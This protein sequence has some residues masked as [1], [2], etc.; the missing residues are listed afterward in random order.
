M[1][2]SYITGS[3]GLFFNNMFQNVPEYVNQIFKDIC[4]KYFIV[5][6]E[7]IYE[8]SFTILLFEIKARDR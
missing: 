4:R 3:T 5:S 6:Y 8:N 2:S 7:N 1:Q